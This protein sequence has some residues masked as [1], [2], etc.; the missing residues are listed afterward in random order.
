MTSQPQRSTHVADGHLNHASDDVPIW[1]EQ[2]RYKRITL[3]VGVRFMLPDQ[4]EYVGRL[5]N[6]SVGGLAIKAEIQPAL[7]ETIIF[8]ID[9][10]GR[11]EGH[12]VRHI[13]GGFATEFAISEMKREKTATTLTWLLNRDVVDDNNARRYP[14]SLLMKKAVLKRDDGREEECE[15]I[16]M[17]L[18]G[19]L[20]RVQ[21]VPPI[22]D[23]INIGKMEGRII[24]HSQEGIGIEFLNVSLPKRQITKDL[25]SK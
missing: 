17:S 21:T 10:L 6:I 12:V 4:T 23:I 11:F 24:R 18:G 15:I 22:G 5:E 8:Y 19:A 1:R 16:D 3:D 13:D 14:R 20:L 25:F 9:D 2:R 7:D